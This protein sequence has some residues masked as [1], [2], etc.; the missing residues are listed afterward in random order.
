MAAS[1]TQELILH[2]RYSFPC[3]GFIDIKRKAKLS[4]QGALELIETLE[5]LK[6]RLEIIY[7]YQEKDKDDG[8]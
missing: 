4:E 6:K 8:K 5:Y 3:G 2:D 7:T 1:E